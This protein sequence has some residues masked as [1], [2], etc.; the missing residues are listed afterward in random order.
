MSDEPAWEVTD[1]WTAYTCPGFD[2]V[3]EEVR[4]PD[5]TETDFDYLSE[6]PAVV[7][8]P[9]TADGEVVVI[10]EWRQAVGRVNYGI[11]VGSMES[12]DGD[13]AAA[14]HREL[15]E[16]TGYEAERVEPLTSA[17]PANGLAD[18]LH[19][20]FVADGCRPTAEQDLDH[21]ETILVD[22]TTPAALREAVASGEVRDGRTALAVSHAVAFGDVDAFEG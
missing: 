17:E 6:P 2:V 16:E 18:S 1:R 14:A 12:A 8:L 19:H 11:P 4:L 9:L 21:D 15:R 22:T 7:V 5:G 13:P 10:E 3:H 20:H